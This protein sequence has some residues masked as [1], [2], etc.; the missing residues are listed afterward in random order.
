MFTLNLR[1]LG[2]GAVQLVDRDLAHLR[3]ARL[4]V[5]AQH[6]LRRFRPPAKNRAKDL[7]VLFV[8]G[9]DPRGL[10]EVEPAHDADA[11]SHV[12]V[13]ARHLMVAGRRHDGRVEGFVQG[14]HFGNVLHAI[15]LRHQPR[16]LE[17]S[18]VGHGLRGAQPVHGRGFENDAQVIQLFELAEIE[19]RHVPAASERHLHVAFQ[20]QP[21]QG[22][23]NR[24]AR[25]AQALG[26]VAFGEA[27]AGQQNE[28]EDRGLDA[29]VGAFGTRE[30]SRVRA[31]IV[32]RG[33]ELGW[34]PHPSK[35]TCAE[36]TRQP[37]GVFIQVWVWRPARLPPSRMNSMCVVAKRSP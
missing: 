18:Q 29:A 26:H 25:H 2:P 11:V 32:A 9:G 33:F 30:C 31:G 34:N 37:C 12:G 17:Q 27:F 21:E 3:L 23:S 6:Q 8:S 5:T 20:L 15:V 14:G 13:H 19:G 7:G 10:R 4:D 28:V 35:L 24:R 16:E 1:G 36:T 22:F